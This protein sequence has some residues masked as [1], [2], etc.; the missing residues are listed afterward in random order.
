MSDAAPRPYTVLG[1]VGVGTFM[2]ALGG[3]LI[4]VAVPIMRRDL[5][6][7]VGEASW[8]LAAYS[9]TVSAL[10]LAA[11]RLGDLAGK[12]LVYTTGFLIFGAGSA[13]CAVSPTLGVLVAS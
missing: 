1:V 13:L 4:N 9:L 6:A 2:S 11:G 5:G 7:D 12:R 10:L 3:S 8:I